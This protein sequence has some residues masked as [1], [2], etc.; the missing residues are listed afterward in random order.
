MS[1]DIHVLES[2][3][4][5]AIGSLDDPEAQEVAKHIAACLICRKELDAFQAV[6]DQL[7]LAV[8]DAS[9][10]ADLRQRL[11][12]RVRSLDE[13]PL[14]ALPSSNKPAAKWS[15]KPLLSFGAVIGLLLIVVLAASN[16]FLWQKIGHLSVLSGANGMRAIALQSSA[17]AP[18][19][20]AFI[21]IGAD[22]Q[23]GVLVV[24]HMPPLQA[25]KEYQLWL[26]RD[27]KNASAAVFSVDPSG[28]RGVRVQAPESLLLFS[29][30]RV[31][32]EPAGGSASPT[33][34]E[35]LSGSLFNP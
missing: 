7:A 16:L 27:G 22:G 35:V 25:G 13:K 29:S 17:V 34:E 9:P 10:S 18:L 8:P 3:P 6:A 23:N 20:S 4:A 26:V 11:I 12:D 14:L 28:Y 32:I 33:G 24:D 5:Y 31:T 15:W 21:V 30:V 1:D 2:L 19:S